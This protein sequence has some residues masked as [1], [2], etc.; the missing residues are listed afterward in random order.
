MGIKTSQTEKDSPWQNHTE[1]EIRELKKHVK[2]FMTRMNAPYSIRDF[3]SQYT[4]ELRNRIAQPLTQLK[5]RTPYE[6]IT[7]NTPE[8]SEFLEFS[9]YQL[10]WYYEPSVFPQQNRY[11]AR[12]LDITHCVGQAMCIARA[13]IHQVKQ[14]EQEQQYSKKHKKI[15]TNFD[16]ENRL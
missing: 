1:V 8:I 2:R 5:V 4:V 13:T 11:L 14:E 16:R 6:V 9:F 10:V 15:L 3:C 12:W 7:G